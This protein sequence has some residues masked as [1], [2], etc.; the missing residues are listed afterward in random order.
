[1]KRILNSK[2]DRLLGSWLFG[3]RRGT[4]NTINSWVVRNEGDDVELRR[5]PTL[6]L[7]ET[8]EVT[9][10]YEEDGLLGCWK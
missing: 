3:K 9:L 2:Y 1:M 7:L 10:N 8:R 5:R 4:P 6:G